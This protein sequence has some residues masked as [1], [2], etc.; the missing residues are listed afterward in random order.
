MYVS[1]SSTDADF[2]VKLVDVLPDTPNIQRMVRA[3]VIRGK[4][5]NSFEKPEPFT[6]G[7]IT[8]VKLTLNDIA[9]TFQKGHR[10]MVQI[11]SSWFPLTDMNP[12]VFTNIPGAKKTDFKKATIRLY[13]DKKHP[14]HIECRRLDQ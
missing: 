3:E 11:Q 14:S 6:A 13:H 8:Q 4:F 1:L 5:R 10:I 7:K 2:V 12:Q 9:H